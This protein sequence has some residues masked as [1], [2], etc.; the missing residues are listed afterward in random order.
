MFT[1][2]N[3]SPFTRPISSASDI[4]WD[5]VVIKNAAFSINYADCCIRWGLYE[6]AN[7]FVGWPIVPRFDVAGTV[8]MVGKGKPDFNNEGEEDFKVG[9]AGLQVKVVDVVDS[10]VWKWEKNETEMNYAQLVSKVNTD[11]FKT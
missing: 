6:S 2:V 1:A 8:E 7:Q 11:M 4:P 5:C 3:S 9:D 10:S